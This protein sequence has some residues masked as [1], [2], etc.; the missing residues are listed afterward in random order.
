MLND[1][2]SRP[3]SSARSTSTRL[4][5]SPVAVTCSAT[6]AR[7]PTG[8]RPARATPQP[9]SAASATPMALSNARVAPTLA[10]SV[11]TVLSGAATCKARPGASGV[12]ST[13]A[14]TPA[15]VVSL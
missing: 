5:G 8:A 10:T 6:A 13:M 9:A 2:A 4:A 14:R 15:S 3:S 7:R 12:V 1:V 11:S